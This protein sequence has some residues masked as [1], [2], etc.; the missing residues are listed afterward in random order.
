VALGGIRQ[1]G[2]ELDHGCR[3][4]H[5]V[6]PACLDLVTHAENMAR[7]IVATKIYCKHGHLLTPTNE[8]RR[9]CL[10]CRK[11]AMARWNQEHTK[12]G[13]HRTILATEDIVQIRK[14]AHAGISQNKLASQYRISRRLVRKILTGEAYPDIHGGPIGIPQIART[15]CQRGHPLTPEN[16]VSHQYAQGHYYC[17]VCINARAR[18]N[19]PEIREATNAARRAKAKAKKG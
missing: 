5:C 10:Q 18:A 11:A 6:Q 17:K 14:D 12:T 7:G 4:R 9:R 2:L 8:G 16:L 15:H 1:P 3:I 13:R 19:W